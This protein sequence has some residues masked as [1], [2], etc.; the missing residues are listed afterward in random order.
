MKI[1][2]FIDSLGSGG[3]QRQLVELGKGFKEKG[4]EVV[5]LTYHEINFFKPELDKVNIPVKTV[6][7]VSYLKRVFKIRKAIRREKPDAVL[8]FLEAANFMATLAGFPFRKWKLVVGER[9]ANPNIFKS[10][11]LR[12]YRWLHL[13]A[14]F[15]VGNSYTNLKMV[16]K[17]NPLLNDKKC[18]VIYNI[19]NI[20]ANNKEE[21]NKQE[22]GKINIAIAASYRPV[23]NLH[24]LIN[25]VGQLPSNLSNQ[26]NIEWY[27][28][29]EDERYYTRNFE[30][31]KREKLNDIIHL[32]KARRN[33][34]DVYRRADF[35]ALFSQ[36]EGFPNAICEGMSL[37]KP[38]IVSE[39]SDIPLFIK[40]GENGYLCNPSDVNSIKGAL[41]KAIKSDPQKRELMGINNFTLVQNKFDREVIINNY[42][43]FL[44][45]AKV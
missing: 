16:K 24:N 37:K 15:V 10:K 36:Y 11:K 4:H 41:L 34:F 35:I 20:P 2:C 44:G 9:S 33:I 42:L 18:R 38:V 26:L 5:F 1:L 23:K 45:N 6:R 8:S 17:I 27:G 12:L 29:P 14:D 3:A 28:N 39:V 32:N 25:A 43:Q 40:E 21:I 13:F 19:V 30:R 31:I 22:T 7:E